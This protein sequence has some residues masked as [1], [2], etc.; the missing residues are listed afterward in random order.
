M[1]NKKYAKCV[2]YCFLRLRE[3]GYTSKKKR[4]LVCTVAGLRAVYSWVFLLFSVWITCLITVA[5]TSYGKRFQLIHST[6]AFVMSTRGPWIL[7][8]RQL[9][10][11]ITQYLDN[12]KWWVLH[13]L[14]TVY[15][16]CC[17]YWQLPFKTKIAAL[18]DTAL[19]RLK[20]YLAFSSAWI[21]LITCY[22]CV[23]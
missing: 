21:F 17:H 4:K 16:S 13:T 22:A 5:T 7:H 1:K 18:F 15:C 2:S 6:Y 10:A 3:P 19:S 23:L 20:S 9:V 8:V 12:D 14:I 11:V